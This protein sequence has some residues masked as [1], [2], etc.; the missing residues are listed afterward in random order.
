MSELHNPYI[1][2]APVTEASMFF[3]REDIFEWIR[4]NLAGQYADHI[5]VIHGQRRVG[6]TSVLK[7]L[8][9]HLPDRYIPVFFDLQGRTHTTLDRFLWWLAREIVRVLKEDRG[10]AISVPDKEAFNADS[11][12]LEA[13]FL[14]SL[15]DHLG[16]RSLLLT[17]DEFDTL[18]ESEVRETLGRPLVDH[19]R[20]LMGLQG[21]NFIFSIGSSGRKLENMQASYTEFFKAAL[22]K[23][24]SFLSRQDADHLIARPVEGLVEYDPTAIQRIYEITSGHPY[25]IQLTCHELFSLCQKTG[26]RHIRQAEVEGVLD[27]VTERGTVNLKFHW[28]EASDLEKWVLAVLAHMEAKDD[29]RALAEFLRRQHVRFSEPEL[30]SAL[31]HLRQKDVL[32]ES[33]RF[34]IYLLQL[35]LRKNRPLEQ[36]R[37]ELTEVNPIATRFIEIGLEYKESGLLEKAIENLREALE[38]DPDNLRAQVNL[39]QVY[40]GQKAYDQAVDEFEKALVIDADDV[41]AR[42]GMCEAHLALGDQASSKGKT[43]EATRSYQSVLAIN[44][45]H[46][47]A[48]QRMAEIHRQRAEEALAKGRDEEALASFVEAIGYVPEDQALEARYREVREEKKARILASLRATA[49]RESSARSWEKAAL[50]L[51]QALELAPEDPPLTQML[52][53]ARASQRADLLRS[54]PGNA[55]SLAGAERWDEAFAAWEEYLSLEPPDPE[56][57]QAEIERLKG[58]QALA[59]TYSEAQAALARRDFDQAIPALKGIIA[60]DETYKDATRLLL[61]AI[62]ARRRA[63]PKWKWKG[64]RLSRKARLGLAAA[65]AALALGA[66]VF[67]NWDQIAGRVLRGTASAV[68]ATAEFVGGSLTET[69]YEAMSVISDCSNGTLFRSIETVDA[70][71]VRFTMCVPDPAFLA[72]IALSP[73]AI[74]PREWLEANTAAGSRLSSP[75]GTGPYMVNEWNRGESLTFTR[76]DDYW[77]T[78]A[79]AQTLVFRWSSE[80]AARLL[81]LQAGTVDGIDDVDPTDFATVEGDPNLQL[82]PRA[83][84]DVS[85]VGMNN[86]FPPFDDVRVRQA[87]AMGIDRQRII[88]QF[89][90]A[91]SEV[92][93]YFTPCAIPNGCVGDPWYDFNPEAAR[94]LLADAGFPDG[95][96]TTITY[97]GVA[98]DYLQEPGRVAEEIQAQLLANLNIRAQIVVM[99][100]DEYTTAVSA[101]TIQGLHFLGWIADYPHITHFLDFHFSGNTQQFGTPFPDIYNLLAQGAHIADPAQAEPLYVRANKAIRELVPAVPI[102]HGGSATAYRADVVNPQAS[103][104]TSEMFGV[105]DPG[106]RDTF[107]WMQNAEPIS[108]FCQDETDSESLRACEQVM[109]GLYGFT[110]NGADVEPVLAESCTPNTDLTVWTCTL[111][112]GVKFHNGLTF[113]ADDVVAS[114]ISG[115]DVNSPLHVGNTGVFNSWV[116]LWGNL[117]GAPPPG[118]QAA[119]PQPTATAMPSWVTDFAQP[120]LDAISDRAPSYQDD[121]GARS[122]RWMED[123]CP[124]GMEFVEGELIFTNCRMYRSNIDWPDFALEFDVRFVEGTTP[125]SYFEFDFRNTANRGHT[126]RIDQNGDVSISFAYGGGVAVFTGA[127]PGVQRNHLVVIARGNRFAFYLNGEPLYYTESDAY[128]YGRCRFRAER[129]DLGGQAILAIDNFRI[130]DLSDLSLP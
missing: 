105:S 71:T 117:I 2:G 53:E 23:K 4:N 13:H 20:R 80:S 36:V 11:E 37:E 81:E 79:I 70:H 51:E 31:L 22:Y 67:M 19:L 12:Y 129:P 115:L 123:W 125:S 109:Q 78:P 24:V 120:I 100:S 90:P 52:R 118:Q 5:L 103:P 50:A 76:F 69:P 122:A 124:G 85:Y 14:P 21:L 106:G 30:E 26:L 128:R 58:I 40:L 92:A 57:A 6:K 42:A 66:V 34:V 73:F 86:N 29:A 95:F 18:E 68:T 49:E 112:Q 126:V 62:E 56:R 46:T 45:E 107:V 75:I 10:I 98:R 64:I 87:I 110:V 101:G 47:E 121:F 38:V 59:Q 104:L 61:Q 94:A 74:Y 102:A 111:R 108:L 88:D 82:V 99:E 28:D 9:R 93:Q 17:F 8:P 16:G 35:W 91:G 63:R 27:D 119:T 97:R 130:W 60:R 116:S 43:R 15:R 96:D 114:F 48:R 44:A 54:L 84:L 41:A 72:K 25:F 33:N 32:T 7:Q 113:D 83:M 1:A 3:G 89:Y 55:E 127:H 39:A 65:L 77:G